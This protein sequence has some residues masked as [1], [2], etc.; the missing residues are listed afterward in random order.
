VRAEQVHDWLAAGAVATLAGNGTAGF[1]GSGGV[2]AAA[3]EA[4]FYNPFAVA[5]VAA[6]DV[7][8]VADGY[9]HAVRV[10]RAS[11][12]ATRTLAGA[13]PLVPTPAPLRPLVHI[14]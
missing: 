10:V 11:D 2:A 7:L 8:F 14:A 6:A 13:G 1:T 5:Y 4:R 12:G 9:N 3:A